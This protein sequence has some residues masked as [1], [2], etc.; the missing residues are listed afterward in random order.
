MSSWL[1]TAPVSAIV[2]TPRPAHLVEGRL[3]LS[4]RC[5]TALPASGV[6]PVLRWFPRGRSQ[7]AIRRA[8]MRMEA[9]EVGTR[10]VWLR[11]LLFSAFGAPLLGALL[12]GTT[13]ITA[14]S[15]QAGRPPPS[16]PMVIA[17]AVTV[18][19][20]VSTGPALA[21]GILCTSLALHWRSQG[22]SR[23]PIV[24]RLAVVG[25]ALGA[26]AAL[27]GASLSEGQLVVSSLYLGPGAVTGLLMG[28]AF[29]R[30]LWGG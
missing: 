23:R 1:K 24:L 21:A 7:A 26:A 4:A 11:G 12:A 8:A 25:I 22:L 10:R 5:P 28:L 6:R 2:T 19:Y 30:A 18:S 29:P 16:I 20:I 17:I 3:M 14:K 13:I 15:L 27:V 9:S